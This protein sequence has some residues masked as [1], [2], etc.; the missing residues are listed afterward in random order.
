MTDTCPVIGGPHNFQLVN[1]N[2]DDGPIR[3]VD[4][5]ALGEADNE[6]DLI[7]GPKPDNWRPSW[8]VYHMAFA[9]LA[10]TRGS[11]DRKRVG[12]T[13][14]L[15]N[16][17]VA[18]GYNGAQRGA[19]SCIEAGHQMVVINGRESCV[20]TLHAEVNAIIQCALTG[21]STLG[22]TIY[23]TASPC[24]E[25][26]KTIAQAGIVRVVFSEAYT[27]ARMMGIDVEAVAL[28][29]GIQWCHLT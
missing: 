18:T 26:I 17:L 6:R 22:A 8:D 15:D 2:D 20:R 9:K 10:A 14:V 24:A 5:K 25:C 28:Q 29:H 23:T 12:A 19:P 13:I 27:G 4:C 11:C 16:R 1:Q 21:I 3:C 7:Q